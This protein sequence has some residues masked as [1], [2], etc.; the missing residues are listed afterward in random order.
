[1]QNLKQGNIY[2]FSLSLYKNGKSITRRTK[3]IEINS[4]KIEAS[5]A[6]KVCL[7]INY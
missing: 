5:V 4:K 3:R 6:T 7:K 2:K 1:M